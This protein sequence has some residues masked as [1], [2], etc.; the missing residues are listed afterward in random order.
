[1]KICFIFRQFALYLLGDFLFTCMFVLISVCS[2]G[3]YVLY[4]TSVSGLPSE[5]I[6]KFKHGFPKDW[7]ELVQ[8]HIFSKTGDGKEKSESKSEQSQKDV[9]LKNDPERTN[10]RRRTN[11]TKSGS[12]SVNSNKLKKSGPE[13]SKSKLNTPESRNVRGSSQQSNKKNRLRNTESGTKSLNSS[14]PKNLETE[15]KNMGMYRTYI[16]SVLLHNAALN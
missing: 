2:N 16:H 6:N 7:Q 5:I 14:I 9:P 13:K 8:E 1:M 15:N 3:L 4:I 11:I 12:E 10:K